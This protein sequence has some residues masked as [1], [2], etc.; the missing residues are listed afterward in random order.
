MYKFN[1]KCVVD[2]EQYASYLRDRGCIYYDPS[3]LKLELPYYQAHIQAL[4]ELIKNYMMFR[5]GGRYGQVETKCIVA[6]LQNVEGCPA[7]YFK[8]GKTQSDSLDTKRVLSRLYDNGYAQQFIEMYVEYKSWK[9]KCGSINS[10]LT[11]CIVPGP[12][13]NAGKQLNKIFFEVNAQVNRRYNYKNEDIISMIPKEICNCVSVDDGYFLAWGDFAQSDFRI[14]LNFFLR[15]E[16]N[17]KLLNEFDDKYEALARM[18]AKTNN[19]EFDYDE[20]KSERQLYKKLVLA[21]MYGTRDSMVEEEQKFIKT[22]TKFLETCE[23]YAEFERRL[24]LRK[25]LG[26]PIMLE[27]YF[28]FMSQIS[29]QYSGN[30]KNPLFQAL[31]NPIQTGTSEL[32]ILTVNAIL[33]EC[34]SNGLTPDDISIYYV[35]HDEP[36]FRIKETAIEAMWTL[37]QFTEILVDDWSPLKLEWSFGY[38]YKVSNSEL[39][40][41]LERVF[42]NNKHKQLQQTIPESCDSHFYPVA[43]VFVAAVDARMTTDGKTIVCIYEE[44]TNSILPKILDT[45]NYEEVINEIKLI[46]R[47]LE[48]AIY[49]KGYRGIIVMNTMFSGEDFFGN[50]FIT[51]KKKEDSKVYRVSKLSSQLSYSYSKKE[52][53]EFTGEIPDFKNYDSDWYPYIKEFEL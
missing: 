4:Y 9:T 3:S 10:L 8:T 38:N 37:D 28:G 45:V 52:G 51:Y 18:V 6:F 24:H 22:F 32:V 46:F 30:N 26:L 48:S 36:I 7:H 23:G 31:N 49:E 41:R 25:E 21:T 50:T 35:R 33:K 27:S 39:T 13:S 34:Y 14:A 47:D 40:E 19:K 53:I 1:R 44:K 15:S 43:D 42:E 17:D 11:R 16:E 2:E 29:L 20:F 5:S 12:V